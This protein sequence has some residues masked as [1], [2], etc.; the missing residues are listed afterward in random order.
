MTL[1]PVLAGGL[2]LAATVLAIGAARVSGLQLDTGD[3]A[4]HLNG[5][6]IQARHVDPAH[7]DGDSVIRFALDCNCAITR[8]S[9]RPVPPTM[10][11]GPWRAPSACWYAPRGE[12]LPRFVPRISRW[13][14]DGLDSCIGC[15][16]L[17]LRTCALHNPDDVKAAVSLVKASGCASRITSAGSPTASPP[18][19]ASRT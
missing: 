5:D 9:K 11:D 10:I 6:T 12:Q 3:V 8:E 7:P 19:S 16:C 4:L 13:V 2:A 14:R 17:S 1:T 18:A 15:G